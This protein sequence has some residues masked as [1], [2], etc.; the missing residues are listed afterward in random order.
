MMSMG[1]HPNRNHFHIHWPERLD[2]EPFAT[3]EEANTRATELV[4]PHETYQIETFNGD[5]PVCQELV[6]MS[7]VRSDAL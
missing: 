2:W 1:D 7:P 3:E 5:C 4:Q 6:R